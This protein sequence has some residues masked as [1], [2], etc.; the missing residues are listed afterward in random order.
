MNNKAVQIAMLMAFIGGFIVWSH[1][2][3]VEKDAEDKFGT[4]VLAVSA[5]KDIK[6]METIDETMLELKR[7]PKRFLEPGAISFNAT[8]KKEDMS[9]DMKDM[10]GFVAIVPVKRGEQITFNKVVEPSLRT[11]LAPQVTPGRRAVTIS[12][13]ET[14][15]VGKLVKPG[16]RVDVIGVLDLG[17]GKDSKIAKTI[18]QDLVVLAV[19]RNVTNNVA[20]LIEKDFTGKN[21]QV[22]SLASYDGFTSVTLEV[23]I[24]QAQTLALVSNTGSS[25]LTLA[26]RNNDDTNQEASG[27]VTIWDVLNA[28]EKERVKSFSG[29]Q[30]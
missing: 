27:S 28:Q 13:T 5:K 3:S 26:L 17:G 14:S 30:R 12:V 2:S 11:G 4:Q 15:G 23:T 8:D 18:L 24:T 1:I 20:R 10:A 9:K 29:R 6:E 21:S 19:G 25:V 22:R 7:V 16:D